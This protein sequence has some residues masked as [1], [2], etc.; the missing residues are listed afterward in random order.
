MTSHEDLKQQIADLSK[1]TDKRI[2]DLELHWENKMDGF[3]N[4]IEGQES[5]FWI[6][7]FYGKETQITLGSKCQK[8]PS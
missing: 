5:Q 3:G 2:T 7:K 4:E 6:A 8:V 1:K